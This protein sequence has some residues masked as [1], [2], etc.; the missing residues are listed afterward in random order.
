MFN[1]D[2][3]IE[4]LDQCIDNPKIDLW[5]DA[6]NQYLPE[7]GI[8]SV[9]R[10]AGF[11]SQTQHESNDFKVLQENLNY[12]W[13]GLRSIFSKY[14]R[15]DDAAKEYH[16]Q[17]EKIANRVY[18]NR[19]GNGD[20]RSGDG[21]K[22][23]GRGILQLTG[24]SNY[25]NCSLDL[26]NNDILVKD[27]DL[28]RQPDYAI[29]SACWFWKKNGLNSF[30]DAMDVKTLSYR[31]NGGWNGL[32]DRI[33]KWEHALAVFGGVEEQKPIRTLKLGSKGNDV[34]LLQ[35]FLR[36]TED[37]D[38]GPGTRRALIEW[39]SANGLDADG[40]AGPNTLRAMFG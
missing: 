30:C 15:S 33:E 37:G 11:I 17:P 3:T 39:Q 40:V 22:Y 19:M 27:P 26:F 18:A 21:W 24:K 28:L 5:F 36:I 7:Q 6:L 35:R 16:R 34:V 4:K 2:F 8:D 1:F 38:F 23:R 12:S 14:F 9:P 32:E 10:V 29:L 25:L 13:Q 31:I 20:E